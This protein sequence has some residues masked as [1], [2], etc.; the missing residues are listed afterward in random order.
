MAKIIKTLAASTAAQSSSDI[1]ETNAQQVAAQ[2]GLPQG[3]VEVEQ[4]PAPKT[5]KAVKA[6][7]ANEIVTLAL[8]KDTRETKEYLITP[9]NDPIF[10]TDRWFAV[11]DLK[12]VEVKDGIFHIQ[13]PRKAVASR[14]LTAALGETAAA[15]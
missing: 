8:P 11:K 7:T 13:L 14:G 12:G 15:H 10:G 4:E 9:K 6:D 3:E 2:G 5:I 1:L